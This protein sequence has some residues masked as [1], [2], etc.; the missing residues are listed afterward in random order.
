[1]GTPVELVKYEQRF[2]RAGLPLFIEDFSP[3]HDIFARATPVLALV[4]LAEVL[5]AIELTW[6]WW[7]NALA[8]LGGL[9]VLI[10]GFGLLNRMRD[11]PFWSFPTRFGRPELAVF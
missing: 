9:A 11:R 6:A 5:G 8:V 1:M 7:Q 10:G 2:R 4:F 3:T